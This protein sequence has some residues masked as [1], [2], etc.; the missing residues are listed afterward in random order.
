MPFVKPVNRYVVVGAV[1]EYGV[2]G[3]HDP[4]AL[5][6]YC[7][8]YDNIGAPPVSTGGVVDAHVTKTCWLSQLSE[9]VIIA[10]PGIVEGVTL[11]VLEGGP[12]PTMFT[13][14]TR[15][16]YSVP[17]VSPVAV[18]DGAVEP[19]GNGVHGPEEFVLRST[20]YPVIGVPP[21]LVGAVHVNITCAFPY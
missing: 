13:A 9:D 5:V 10:G 6:L 16:K 18:Y 4:V 7:M 8:L 11:I 12:V 15:K 21:V 2:I 1:T 14:E 3:N 17:F 19:V 20:I